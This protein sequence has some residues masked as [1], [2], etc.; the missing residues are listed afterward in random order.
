VTEE[1]EQLAVWLIERRPANWD[2]MG[3]SAKDLWVERMTRSWHKTRE[4]AR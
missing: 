2:E 4:G 1:S 3:S